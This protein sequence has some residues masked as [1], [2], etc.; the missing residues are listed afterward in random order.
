MM[1]WVAVPVTL[2]RL[3]AVVDAGVHWNAVDRLVLWALQEEPQSPADLAAQLGVPTR[4]MNEIVVKLMRFGWVEMQPDTLTFRASLAGQRA[5]YVEGGLPSLEREEPRG[6]RVVIEPVEGKVFPAAEVRLR[7]KN[8]VDEIA[9]GHDVRRLTANKEPVA[10]FEDLGEAAQSC[11]RS[12]EEFVRLVPER[13]EAVSRWILVSV[14][15][16]DIEG[17]PAAAPKRLVEQVIALAKA[18]GTRSYVPIVRS[19]P[20]AALRSAVVNVNVADGDVLLDGDSHR[21]L[22]GRVVRRARHRVVIHSTFL[23]ADGFARLQ[24]DLRVAGRNG[25]SIDIVYGADKDERTRTKNRGAATEITSAIGGDPI[26]RHRAKMHTQSTQSHAKI[27]VADQG[28]ED[29]WVAVVGSCNWLSTGYH[30]VEGSVVLRDA[31][32]VAAVVDELRELC[33]AAAPQARLV[34]D[35]DGLACALHDS[36][37]TRGS[38]QV[39]L[40]L[41]DEHALMMARARDDAEAR[42]WVGGDRFSQA[43]EAQTL[44][45]MMAAAKGGVP[46]PGRLLFSRNVSPVT[47]EDLAD[48]EMMARERG[49]TLTEVA[50]GVLHGKFLLWDEDDVVITSLNWSSANTRRDNPWGEI[51]IHISRSGIAAA[52]AQQIDPS[53]ERAVAE[54]S[55]REPR[56]RHRRRRA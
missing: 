9:R 30:R 16:D 8:D 27:L 28:R 29:E 50:E 34:G 2:C 51:G 22:F 35:L 33:Y 7:H 38:A 42:I 40:V 39:R 45:P 31:R 11:L 41:G 47:D 4:L 19:T 18:K 5:L 55:R 46:V 53:I 12:E 21:E 6:V 52:V 26:L 3:Q 49:V 24:D 20:S 13:C 48:L 14:N 43:G 17:L 23:S 10:R 37:G 56:R 15:G 1:V 32:L 54:I 25:A 44:I 36:R